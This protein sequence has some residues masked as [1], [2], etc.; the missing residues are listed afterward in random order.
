MSSC[1]ASSSRIHASRKSSAK[2]QLAAFRDRGIDYVRLDCNFGAADTIGGASQLTHD[3][4]FGRLAAAAK[5]CQEQQ[6]VPLVL[7][8][9]QRDCYEID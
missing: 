3:P 2:S 8:Q 1:G 5:A 7:L 4:R 6:M 9:V